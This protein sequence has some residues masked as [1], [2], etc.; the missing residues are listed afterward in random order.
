M[1][2]VSI[3]SKAFQSSIFIRGADDDMTVTEELLDRVSMLGTTTR[4]YLYFCIEKSLENAHAWSKLIS[5]TTDNN[6]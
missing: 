5:V 2:E 4:N 6:L 3:S 1:K